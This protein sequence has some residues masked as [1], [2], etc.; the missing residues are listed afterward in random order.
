V[1]L[2]PTPKNETPSGVVSEG[3][4]VKM[5]H[6]T[7]SQ[8]TKP[9]PDGLNQPVAVEKRVEILYFLANLNKFG[10]TAIMFLL[11]T[12][13]N[14][15]KI[16]IAKD[17]LSLKKMAKPIYETCKEKYLDELPDIE[18]PEVVTDEEVD[19]AIIRCSISPDGIPCWITLKGLD[20][21]DELD[22]IW[23]QVDELEKKMSI[24]T[25]SAKELAKRHP[26]LNPL[27]PKATKAVW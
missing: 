10:L 14:T 23:R 9:L 25:D 21:P 26:K 22:N 7:S 20:D 2:A 11:Q 12:A 1:V 27:I 15:E 6:K 24:V 19:R 16:N 5:D 17:L 3:G 13:D 18:I 8:T 4:L